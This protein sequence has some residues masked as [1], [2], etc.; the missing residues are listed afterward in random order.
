MSGWRGRRL[1]VVT[2]VSL[3]LVGLAGAVEVL[4]FGMEH[5][6]ALWN[7]QLPVI[8]IGDPCVSAPLEELP[9][10]PRLPEE[11][12]E[13]ADL[14][15]GV[16]E[17]YRVLS[18]DMA[19]GR[20]TVALPGAGSGDD[21]V[22]LE[23]APGETELLA[24]LR[25][26]YTRASGHSWDKVAE[27]FRSDLDLFEAIFNTRPRDLKFALGTKRVLIKAFLNTKSLSAMYP[28]ILRTPELTAIFGVRRS[29]E[30]IGRANAYL[31]NAGGSCG[32]ELFVVYPRDMVASEAEQHL[33][34]LLS[35]SR[36]VE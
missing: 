10:A 20:A 13:L 11:R 3:S 35:C 16:P 2:S 9:S 30:R 17:P 25:S 34:R 26:D 28:K 7:G 24:E 4:G 22:R 33:A 18:T 14:L 6:Y 32:G 29:G 23:W 19:S 5:V 1:A 36:F 31:F 12:V 15:V 21:C 27:A 8:G